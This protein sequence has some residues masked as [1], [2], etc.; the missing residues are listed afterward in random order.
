M[1]QQ[2]ATQ[3]TTNNTYT[4]KQQRKDNNRRA[5]TKQP[6]EI[7]KQTTITSHSTNTYTNTQHH[8]KR[9][10]QRNAGTYKIQQHTGNALKP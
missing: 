7:D 8:T 6:N 3:H 1:T 10:E 5:H 9:N 4:A 2:P